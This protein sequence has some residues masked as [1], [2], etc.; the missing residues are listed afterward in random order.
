MMRLTLWSLP[1]PALLSTLS[2]L[3]SSRIRWSSLGDG[4]VK[5]EMRPR[6]LLRRKR[7][8][9]EA[10]R[11]RLFQ[12]P[13]TELVQAVQ[14]VKFRC[15][16]SNLSPAGLRNRPW[17]DPSRCA[18][19][20]EGIH[21]QHCSAYI[22]EWIVRERKASSKG[23]SSARDATWETYPQPAFRGFG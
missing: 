17:L 1:T 20:L 12:V 5:R 13:P 23:K 19:E 16:S 11:R 8:M 9:M 10:G 22:R 7:Q 18:C 4:E 14:A 6:S 21:L 15:S 3:H 2:V